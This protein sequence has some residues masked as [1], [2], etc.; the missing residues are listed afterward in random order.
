MAFQKQMA[1]TKLIAT[2]RAL[3]FLIPDSVSKKTQTKTV[4]RTFLES[5]EYVCGQLSRK[6]N[7]VLIGNSRKK[8]LIL[9]VGCVSW[10]GFF[11][12]FIEDTCQSI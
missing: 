7:T 11:Y 12:L 2:L 8:Q 5:Q 4:C 6:T 1:V 9:E 3:A 10:E